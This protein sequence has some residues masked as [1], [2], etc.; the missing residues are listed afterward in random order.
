MRIL[1]PDPGMVLAIHGLEHMRQLETC[2]QGT[3]KLTPGDTV[4][5]R[6]GTGQHC[7]FVILAGEADKVR[8]D[9]HIVKQDLRIEVEPPG[10]KK[11]G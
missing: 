5:P 11:S 9:L 2:H 8:R 10:E 3:C 7:G 1:Q 6:E 4:G